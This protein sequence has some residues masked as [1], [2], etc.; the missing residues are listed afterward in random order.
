MISEVGAAG[1]K[2]GGNAG[3]WCSKEPKLSCRDQRGLRLPPQQP[4]LPQ[5]PFLPLF[6]SLGCLA[7]EGVPAPLVSPL[8]PGVLVTWAALRLLCQH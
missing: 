7:D 5:T 2:V 6:T 4:Q 8:L 1:R 3:W